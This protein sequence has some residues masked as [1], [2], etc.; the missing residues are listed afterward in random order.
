MKRVF[1]MFFAPK[2][3]RWMIKMKKKMD[4]HDPATSSE[5]ESKDG[6]ISETNI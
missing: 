1:R 3:K 4:N 2:K 6:L 5:I